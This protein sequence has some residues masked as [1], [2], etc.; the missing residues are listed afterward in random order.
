M[1]KLK[2]LG[3]VSA[4]AVAGILVSIGLSAVAQRETRS[5]LPLDTLQERLDA[6]GS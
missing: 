5:T 6:H 2:S 3:L 1:G 4:G